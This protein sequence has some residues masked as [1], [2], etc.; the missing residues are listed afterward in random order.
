M[1]LVLQ[2][3]ISFMCMGLKQD[4]QYNDQG[5]TQ[6]KSV[7]Q[8]LDIDIKGQ[9]LKLLLSTFNISYLNVLKPLPLRT[10][11]HSLHRSSS[12]WSARRASSPRSPPRRSTHLHLEA[13]RGRSLRLLAFKASCA[14]PSRSSA[15]C[16]VEEIKMGRFQNS[17]HA[18]PN[19]N[20]YFSIV[21]P[22]SNSIYIQT[23]IS[24]PRLIRYWNQF[25][26]KHSSIN[27][28]ME[29]AD[30]CICLVLHRVI[31]FRTNNNYVMRLLEMMSY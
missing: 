27:I 21:V 24:A 2:Q 30:L 17:Q 14:L 9:N 12:R 28:Q 6:G 20:R 15:P 3:Q 1:K 18:H 4:G 19:A 16:S 29:P 31:L 26:A 10:R 11:L 25:N 5:L 7:R 13:L 22:P 8:H 23:A